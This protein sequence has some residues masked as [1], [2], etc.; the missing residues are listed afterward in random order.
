MPSKL[1]R[2]AACMMVTIDISVEVEEAYSKMLL[3]PSLLSE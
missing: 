3:L 1:L 2:S